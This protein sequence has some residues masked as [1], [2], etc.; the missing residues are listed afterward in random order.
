VSLWWDHKTDLDAIKLH[1]ETWKFWKSTF[2]R[3]HIEGKFNK[4]RCSFD[5]LSLS[6]KDTDLLRFNR[7]DHL[8]ENNDTRKIENEKIFLI[9]LTKLK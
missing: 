8:A 9:R 4:I 7:M 6:K 2:P 5:K 3:R 1:I